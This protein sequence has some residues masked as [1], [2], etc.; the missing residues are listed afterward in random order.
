M[1]YCFAPLEGVTDRVFRRV[2]A[3]SFPGVD[4]YYIPFLSPTTRLTFS[5]REQRELIPDPA[6]KVPT[7]PQI[8]AK[9]PE[10]FLITAR[11]LR[12]AGYPEI[13][14]NLGCP[15]GTVTAKGKGSAML[16]EPDALARFLDRVFAGQDLK[17]SVKT[18]I[19]YESP[20]EWDALLDVLARYPFTRVT[21]HPRTR[22]QFYRGRVHRECIRTALS[23]LKVPVT[24]NGDLFFSEDV[25]GLADECP[26]LGSVMLGRGLVAQPALV[27]V[28]QGGPALKRE[29]LKGFHDALLEGYREALWPPNAILGHMHELMWYMGSCFAD[30]GKELKEI[31]KSKNMGQYLNAAERLFDR[32]PLSSHPGFIPPGKEQEE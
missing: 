14:L 4:R 20:E 12:D 17:I 32:C 23:R 7:I 21:I 3:A 19:G 28:L 8:L 24:A 27:R 22:D 13:D 9:D 5:G 25:S 30:A 26:G 16:R 15:S 2:H 18:R 1:E 31:R 29:E 10:L 6:V 11:L